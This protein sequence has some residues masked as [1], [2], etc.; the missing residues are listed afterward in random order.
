M[1]EVIQNNRALVIGIIVFFLAYLIVYSIYLLVTT[2]LGSV[3]IRKQIH[4]LQLSSYLKHHY[5]VPISILIPTYNNAKEVVKTV[6]SLLRLN[7]NLYEIIVVDDASCDK[8]IAS[9]IKEFDLHLVDRP[10]RRVLE[11]EAILEVYQ[12]S[13]QKVKITVVKKEHS[14]KADSLNVGINIADYPY[15]VVLEDGARVDRDVLEKLAAPILEDDK[16]VLCKGC[17]RILDE[18]DQTVL[19]LAQDLSYNRAYYTKDDPMEASLFCLFK[20]EMAIEVGGYDLVGENFELVRKIENHCQGSI[21]KYIIKSALNA[22]C[23]YTAPKSFHSIFK[24]KKIWMKSFVRKFFK[25]GN[26]NIISSF[27]YFFYEIVSYLILIIGLG[28]IFIGVSYH[29]ISIDVMVCFLLSYLLFNVVCTIILY[30]EMGRL[31]EKPKSS[32]FLGKLL[33]ATIVDVV[34]LGLVGEAAKPFAGF[35]LDKKKVY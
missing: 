9:L 33:L 2:I 30:L 10:I 18:R 22:L 35:K 29:F 12:T 27:Y 31:L 23:Y 5:Y 25:Y 16:V 26:S 15:F 32:I 8:T 7:Y 17:A 21:D 34:F 6:K 4:R 1:Q 11:T 28:A 20:K 14:G 19:A 24:Q 3:R 13:N